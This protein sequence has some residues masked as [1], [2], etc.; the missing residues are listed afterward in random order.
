MTILIGLSGYAAGAWAMPGFTG[1]TDKIDARSAMTE[2]L[3]AM[4]VSLLF[5]VAV[6]PQRQLILHASFDLA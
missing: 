5:A 4:G 2:C 6:L 3:R 1:R